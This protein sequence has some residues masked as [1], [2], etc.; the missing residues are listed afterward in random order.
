LGLPSLLYNGTGS[1]SKEV[2]RPGRDVY[3]PPKSR[4][5]VKVRVVITAC[6]RVKYVFK[7]E[8]LNSAVNFV[9]F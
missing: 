1:L 8:F 2:K 5:K 9:G 6:S 4:A 3:H 7:E